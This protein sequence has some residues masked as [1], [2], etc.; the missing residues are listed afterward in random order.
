MPWFA[1]VAEKAV[2]A[3]VAVAAVPVMA[4]L[5]TVA[6]P[7]RRVRLN[8]PNFV[9]AIDDAV[10]SVATVTASGLRNAVTLAGRLAKTHMIIIMALVAVVVWRW[11]AAQC[12]PSTVTCVTPII[13]WAERIGI[14]SDAQTPAPTDSPVTPTDLPTP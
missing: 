11:N 3:G 1:K 2:N 14:G 13:A 5:V 7:M 4:I 8:P 10:V 12:E 9:L 6:A